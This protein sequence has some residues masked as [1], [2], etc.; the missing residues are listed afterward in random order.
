MNYTNIQQKL[1]EL[2]MLRLARHCS[3]AESTGTSP[4]R[5]HTDTASGPEDK[6]HVAQGSAVVGVHSTAAA[7]HCKQA[8]ASVVQRT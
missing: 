1:N 8:W 2:P 4:R 7:R 5:Q 3:T 6:G